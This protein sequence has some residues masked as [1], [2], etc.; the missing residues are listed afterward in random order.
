MESARFLVG[1]MRVT[2]DEEA[3]RTHFSSESMMSHGRDRSTTII[4]SASEI[5]S[6][7]ITSCSMYEASAVPFKTKQPILSETSVVDNIR[8]GQ[9]RLITSVH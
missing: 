2:E 7:V 5:S 4:T 1:L 6:G 3:F 8:N 9:L